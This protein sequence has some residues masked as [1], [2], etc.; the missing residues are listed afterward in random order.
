MRIRLCIRYFLPPQ[1][2]HGFGFF[3]DTFFFDGFFAAV[4]FGVIPLAAFRFATR[5]AFLTAA[6]FAWARAFEQQATI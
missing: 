5:V 1:I 4:F 6:R 3:A 2:R